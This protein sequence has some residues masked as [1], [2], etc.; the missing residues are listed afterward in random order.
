MRILISTRGKLSLSDSA[1]AKA[2]EL[3]ESALEVG[4]VSESYRK[5]EV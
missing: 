2:I 5:A 1:C 3:I 4:G